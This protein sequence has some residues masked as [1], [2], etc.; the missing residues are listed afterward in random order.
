M[1]AGNP[2]SA[3]DWLQELKTN[4]RT[5]IAAASF[6]VVTPILI[7]W[8][9]A[10]D[11]PKGRKAAAGKVAVGPTRLDDRQIKGLEKLADISKLR[12]AGELQQETEVAR[13]P[14]LFEGVAPVMVTIHRP[15][16]PPPPKTAEELEQERI[17]AD[18]AAQQAT[19]PKD[20]RYLGTVARPSKGV[21]AG[22]MRGEE[23]LSFALGSIAVKGW[24]LVKAE[25]RHAEFQNLKYPELTHKVEAR[26]GGAAQGPGN[27]PHVTNQF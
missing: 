10:D 5:Q 1:S 17:A 19:A 18:K 21:F 27:R 22:F 14:F 6:L 25:E 12:N 9:F 23:A 8:M 26:E 24:K 16:P 13:D 4:R 7:Y 2:A 15:D 3:K 20:L 11:K